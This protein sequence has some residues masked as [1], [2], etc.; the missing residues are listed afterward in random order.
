MPDIAF[1]SARRLA[2]MIRRGRIGSLELLDRYLARVEKYNPQLNAIVETDIAAAR[3]R[4]AAAAP[5]PPRGGRRGP[6][7]AG[8]VTGKD[9]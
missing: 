8:A 2:G 5:P 6:P 3:R 7:P 9:A 1:S 4:A